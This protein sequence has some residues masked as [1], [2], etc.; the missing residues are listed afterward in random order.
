MSDLW[1]RLCRYDSSPKETKRDSAVALK[2]C[3]VGT[4]KDRHGLM[5]TEHTH[6]F[7]YLVGAV[8]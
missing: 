8:N 3:C 7:I 6:I 1:A 4:D 2:N 5:R